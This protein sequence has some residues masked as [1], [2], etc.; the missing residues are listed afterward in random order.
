VIT[1]GLIA[2]GAIKHVEAVERRADGRLCDWLV[3]GS[4]IVLARL[5]VTHVVSHVRGIENDAVDVTQDRDSRREKA[6]ERKKRGER[7][8]RRNI[9]AR[10]RP[11]DKP[12]ILPTGS[13]IYAHT[14]A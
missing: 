1:V 3:R 10:S 12:P 13:P 5:A 6:R 2:E 7:E 8:R 9:G 4:G 11:G 14:R